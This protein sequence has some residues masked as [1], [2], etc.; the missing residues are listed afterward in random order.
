MY[1]VDYAK[2]L[3]EPAWQNFCEPWWKAP[4][5]MGTAFHAWANENLKK[6]NGR[7]VIDLPYIEFDS[8]EDFIIFKLT[9]A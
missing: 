8:E 5:G 1:K 3:S 2:M 6:H 9:Y 7:K 4:G